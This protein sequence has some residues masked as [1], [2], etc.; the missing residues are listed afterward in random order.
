MNWERKI[1]KQKSVARLLRI[2][3]VYLTDTAFTVQKKQ[4][5]LNKNR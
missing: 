1:E 5:L 2:I 3:F 4:S